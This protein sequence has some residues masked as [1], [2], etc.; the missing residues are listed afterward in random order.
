MRKYGFN[1]NK[2]KKMVWKDIL[3]WFK[4]KS[5]WR[6]L[7]T[8]FNFKKRQI[9]LLEN[10][11]QELPEIRRLKIKIKFLIS[12]LNYLKSLTMNFSLPELKVSRS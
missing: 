4:I 5:G 1:S 3:N 9:K 6:Y 2:P 8:G 10:K 7:I 11:F 12:V